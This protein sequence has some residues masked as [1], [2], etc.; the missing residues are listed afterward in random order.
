MDFGFINQAEID[1]YLHLEFLKYPETFCS[2]YELEPTIV[3]EQCV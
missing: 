2:L 1:K 3:V